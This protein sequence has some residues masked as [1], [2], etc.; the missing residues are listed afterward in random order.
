MH[1]TF[2]AV[3]LGGVLACCAG[4][5]DAYSTICRTSAS[6]PMLLRVVVPMEKRQAFIEFLRSEETPLALGARYVGGAE[7]DRRLSICFLEVPKR[8]RE[9]RIDICAENVKPSGVFDFSF[10]TCNTRMSWKPYF[11]ATSAHV[12]ELDYVSIS[13][14]PVK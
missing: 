6:S 5:A 10:Q 3:L 4:V 11:K 12:Q 14:V 8:G 2:T 13:E 7:S 1:A 9:P